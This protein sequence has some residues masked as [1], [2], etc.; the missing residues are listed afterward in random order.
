MT[1]FGH[2]ATN[3]GIIME[4]MDWRL[5]TRTLARLGRQ[6]YQRALRQGCVAV[7]FIPAVRNVR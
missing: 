4:L 2:N 6:G 5:T 7:K 1:L 3:C